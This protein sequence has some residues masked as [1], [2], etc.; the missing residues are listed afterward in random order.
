M[1]SLLIWPPAMPQ[2][3]A[4][5]KAFVLLAAI[6]VWVWFFVGHAPSLLKRWSTDK[7]AILPYALVAGAYAWVALVIVLEPG[8]PASEVGVGGESPL[9]AVAA[10]IAAAAAAFSAIA[11]VGAN[12]NAENANAVFQKQLVLQQEQL[13][14]QKEAKFRVWCTVG[15]R[16]SQVAVQNYGTS[17]ILI[18]RMEL[19]FPWR[20]R[21]EG[22]V[23]LVGHDEP[24][25]VNVERNSFRLIRL[26]RGFQQQLGEKRATGI[27]EFSLR[28]CD[29]TNVCSVTDPQR[30]D[31]RNQVAYNPDERNMCRPRALTGGGRSDRAES[32]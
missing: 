4:I 20:G 13:V 27:P 23:I 9:S 1:D 5:V 30:F 15:Y 32:V 14:L 24:P 19:V 6:G 25:L 10:V 3:M 12:R 18:A 11:A 28:V 2:P 7:W 21:P 26:G 8:S 17:N 29:I 16:S 31:E 22:I